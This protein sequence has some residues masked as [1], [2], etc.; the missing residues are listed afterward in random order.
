MPP[1]F[2]DGITQY[3]FFYTLPMPTTPTCQA[4]MLPEVLDATN[5]F[6]DGSA[7]GELVGVVVVAAAVALA[8]IDPTRLAGRF[9]LPLG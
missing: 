9:D 1:I 2:D 5:G 8:L 4:A 6:V 7:V 3:V